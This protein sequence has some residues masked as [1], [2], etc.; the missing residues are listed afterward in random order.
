MCQK[1]YSLRL[2]KKVEL[3]QQNLF[4]LLATKSCSQHRKVQDERNLSRKNVMEYCLLI[5]VQWLCC[6]L[7]TDGGR[8]LQGLLDFGEEVLEELLVAGFVQLVIESGGEEL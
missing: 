4:V 8:S 6:S 3:L 2:S 7:L 5:I 1:R